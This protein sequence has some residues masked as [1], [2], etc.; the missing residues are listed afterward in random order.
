VCMRFVEL[1]W[2]CDNV[3]WFWC[4]VSSL[5]GGERWGCHQIKLGAFGF[6]LPFW[7]AVSAEVRGGRGRSCTELCLQQPLSSAVCA[8]ATPCRRQKTSSGACWCWPRR[9]E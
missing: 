9:R 4:V 6:P 2:L 7:A 1:I 3:R 8:R 5:R